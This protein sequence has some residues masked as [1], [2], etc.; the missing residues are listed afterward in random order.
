MSRWRPR[1]PFRLFRRRAEFSPRRGIQ[2][3]TDGVRIRWLG[4]AG[5]LVEGR[6]TTLL[7]DPYVTRSS[8][9]SVALRRLSP[10][11]EAIRAHVPAR[12]DAVLCG[13]SHFDHLLDAPRIARLTGAQ[14]IGS[15]TTC[16]Y[17]RA[18]GVAPEKLVLIGAAAQ[19]VQVGEFEVTF[20]PS[21]HGRIFWGG[22]LCPASSIAPPRCPRALGNT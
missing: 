19:S 8:L 20:F 17:G 5:Y 16:A 13:H 1:S 9:S 11:E 7:I 21:L 12:V 4:T 14:L 18:E 22:C 2:G 6:S 10:D 3:A 15:K